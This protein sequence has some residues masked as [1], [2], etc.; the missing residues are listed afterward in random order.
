MG[1]IEVGKDHVIC[2]D[3]LVA[4]KGMWKSTSMHILIVKMYDPQPLDKKNDLWSTLIALFHSYSQEIIVLQ[5]FIK[6]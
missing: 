6:V 1:L 2:N 3:N 5:N 4:I